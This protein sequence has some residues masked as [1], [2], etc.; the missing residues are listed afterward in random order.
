MKTEQPL[1]V[2][3]K[4]PSTLET[5]KIMCTHESNHEHLKFDYIN[6]SFYH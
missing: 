1:F 5:E 4:P 3:S 6:I 2:Y